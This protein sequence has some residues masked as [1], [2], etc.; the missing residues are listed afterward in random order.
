MR[1]FVPALL[2]AIFTALALHGLGAVP[3]SHE[4]EAWLAAPGWSFWETGR[5]ASPAFEGFY[6]M[7]RHYYG[8]LPLFPILVGGAMHLFGPTLHAARLVPLALAAATLALTWA[9][10]R[11]L[12]SE[13][14]ALVALGIL[15]LWPVAAPVAHLTTGVP[16]LDL[17]RH[18][19]NDVAAAAF[20]VAALLAALPAIAERRDRPG[21]FLAAGFLA[22]L[23]VL[24]HVYALAF[25]ASILAALFVRRRPARLAG[26]FLLGLALPILPYALFVVSG[27]RDYLLQ[28]RNYASRVA[29]S[30]R[31]FAWN[32]VHERTR[33]QLL[34]RR[35]LAGGPAA[36]LFLA[37][38]GA[39]LVA[40]WRERRRDAG[41]LLAPILGVPLLFALFL[42]P[43]NVTYLA[44]IWPLL[45]LAGSAGLV[46]AWR[47]AR[48]PWRLLLGT[49]TLAA[50]IEG[51]FAFGKLLVRVAETT[52]Y[53][54][55]GARLRT[56]VP[57]R[58]RVLAMHSW[59]FALGPGRPGYRSLFIPIV[60]TNP[61]FTAE[62]HPFAESA[63]RVRPELLLVDPA[64]RRFLDETGSD[65]ADL[66][67]GMRAYLAERTLLRARLDDPS[68]GRLELYGVRPS[69]PPPAPP[70][71]PR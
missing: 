9:L 13:V 60:L 62:T 23:A 45:A 32:F 39:G 5:F 2:L 43:K 24:G 44:P 31:F 15:A 57:A 56:L 69:A 4:D 66:R 64:I 36:V 33:Y 3:L 19:R 47:G 22:G 28:N 67:A 59:W 58:S 51:T 42:E 25:A 30:P 12:L 48:T 71:P 53:A 50:C 17:A 27:W 41:L 54:V 20:G 10:A 46:A 7:D 55:L 38:V 34:T 18:V 52:P 37:T 16:M 6:G 29:F 26:A 8:F 11:R 65:F 49:M 61:R 40:L 14:H 35:A 21:R 68:Y 1:R 70:P 63:D